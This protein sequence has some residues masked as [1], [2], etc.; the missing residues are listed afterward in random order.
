MTR[1]PLTRPAYRHP[2]LY[3]KHVTLDLSGEKKCCR[4]TFLERWLLLYT[5][6]LEKKASVHQNRL[7]RQ[8]NKGHHTL[9]FKCYLCMDFV[10]YAPA[11]LHSQ[12]DSWHITGFPILR[13]SLT[14]LQWL[15][16]RYM[17]HTENTRLDIKTL[18]HFRIWVLQCH[19]G[20]LT[21]V[22]GATRHLQKK[23]IGIW[24]HNLFNN[25]QATSELPNKT[26]RST[27]I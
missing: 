10:S 12:T 18:R 27:K 4:R 5:D 15:I 9:L 26:D 17:R 13:F 14:V 2:L 22:I 6:I 19:N 24:F 11:F 16:Q 3:T 21:H 1:E 20:H 23:K 25:T 8:I 7:S